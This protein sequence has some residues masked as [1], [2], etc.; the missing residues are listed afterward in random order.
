MSKPSK[1]QK[2]RDYIASHPDKS[3]KQVATILRVIPAYVYKIKSE[4]KPKKLILNRTQVEVANKLGISTKDYAEQVYKL[5]SG[6]KRPATREEKISNPGVYEVP[7]QEPVAI[8][9]QAALDVQV[10]GAHYK[11]KRIQPVEFSYANNLNGLEAS[12]VK[13]I[14]RWRDKDGFQDLEKIKHEI[15]LLIELETKYPQGE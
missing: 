12:I 7:V 2:I 15:D 8:P 1:A 5:T 4:L 3:V 10:G 13:R 9:K 11:N 6:R 14:T